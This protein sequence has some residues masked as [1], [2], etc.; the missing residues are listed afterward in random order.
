MN[1]I[2][3]VT[4]GV[5]WCAPRTANGSRWASSASA[6]AAVG[7]I[8]RA[9]TR[10]SPP[11]TNGFTTPSAASARAHRITDQLSR[12]TWQRCTKPAETKH[13]DYLTIGN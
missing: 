4:E 1:C 8:C 2:C 12:N 7:P 11:S 9:F 3:R 6:S 10:V 5:H 13:H